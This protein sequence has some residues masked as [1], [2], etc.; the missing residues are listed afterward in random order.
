MSRARGDIVTFQGRQR[1]GGKALKAQSLGDIPKRFSDGVKHL[2]IKGNQVHLVNCQHD[3]LDAHQRDQ[4]SVPTG[5]RQHTLPSVDQQHGHVYRRGP[6]DHVAGVLLVAGRVGHDEL[7]PWRGKKAVGHVDSN[8]LLTLGGKA[9]DQQC[10]VDAIAL[11]AMAFG[12]GLQSRQL[13][14][15]YLLGLP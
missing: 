12:V 1:N 2:A 13:I 9:V 7:A 5:L 4:I 10:K 6:G 3:V 15:K 14:I 8:A 11:G